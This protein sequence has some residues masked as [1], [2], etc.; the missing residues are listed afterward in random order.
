MSRS[1]NTPWTLAAAANAITA[2]A[3]PAKAEESSERPTIDAPIPVGPRRE[4]TAAARQSRRARDPHL[5]RDVKTWH[6]PDSTVPRIA[7]LGP[8]E[9]RAAGKTPPGRLRFYGEIL[10]YLAQAGKRGA[11]RH[12]LT[13]ALWPDR[14]VKQDGNYL[15]A[16]LTHAR[17]W[18]GRQPD[19]EHWLPEAGPGRIYRLTDG[20]LLDTALFQRLRIRGE[21]HGPAGIKDLH[22]ALELVR[23]EPLD[24]ADRPYASHTRNPYTWLPT[25]NIDP[26][27]LKSAVVDVAHR[28]ADMCLKVGDTAGARW[29][30]AQGCLADTG[31]D[32]DELWI[33]LI[34]IEH[35]EGHDAAVSRT[36]ASMLN[37]RDCE[38][39]EELVAYM[40]L[41]PYLPE[42]Q[43][44]PRRPT[45]VG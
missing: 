38:D 23:G 36:L 40:R 1:P 19:G 15:R 2:A 29:A 3:N 44:A 22:T 5:D 13:E 17:Q 33:D 14:P 12:Q 16:G 32:S 11:D 10:V 34:R 42:E 41:L 20:V 31:R 26:E 27:D 4:A 45:P 7:V 35:D 39:P 25:S 30:V 6:D 37:Y 21:A 43:S 8:V 9:V 24:G 18:L 28:M